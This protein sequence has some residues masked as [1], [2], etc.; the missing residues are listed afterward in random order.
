MAPGSF[1]KWIK[2]QWTEIPEYAEDLTGKTVVVIGANVGLGYE[3]AKKLAGMNPGRLILGCRSQAKGD[4]AIKSIKE[5]TG[6]STM[7]CWTIDMSEFKSISAF[8]DRFEREGGPRLDILLQNAGVLP[9]K[10]IPTVDG[11]ETC[12]Q[13]NYIATSLLALLFLPK[14]NA[15]PGSSRLVIVSSDAPYWVNKIRETEAE[16]ILNALND[17]A[18][19]K[20]SERYSQTKLFEMFFVRALTRRMNP[21]LSV[22]VTTVN[23]GFCSSNLGRN[24][25]WPIS[26]ILDA[27]VLFTGRSTEVGSRTLVHASLWGTKDTVNG[28]F[29]NCCHVEEECDYILHDEKEGRKVENRLWGELVPILLNADPRVEKILEEYLV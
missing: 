28:K 11:W 2:D 23:P 12:L 25:P 3:A 20:I 14:L 18:K 26:L 19:A 17:P 15:T 13:V 4:A 22:A 10:F 6:C 1:V 5:S 9:M 29:L 21:S 8:V 16:H 7:E 24:V 27:Y